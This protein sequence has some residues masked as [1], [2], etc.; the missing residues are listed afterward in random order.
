MIISNLS[1]LHTVGRQYTWTNGHVFCRI[2]R[3]LVNDEWVI[4]MPPLQGM[5]WSLYSQII[6]LSI[7]LKSQRDIRKK[8]FRFYNCLAKHPDFKTTIQSSWKRQNGGMQ[9]VWQNLKVVRREMQQLNKKDYVGVTK[10]VQQ[11]T[12]ELLA[13]QN[14]MRN[15]H[16]PQ[17]MVEEEKEMRAQLIKW[18]L[19][20][21]SIYKQKS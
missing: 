6:P 2:D 9:G 10:K 18:I 7:E 13:K 1:E 11:I 15:T 8:P 3:A 5:V 16:I 17:H 4:R 12:R 20:E 19:I 21:E 14:Q